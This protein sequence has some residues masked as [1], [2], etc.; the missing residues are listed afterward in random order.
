M[1]RNSSQGRRALDGAI[2]Q[3]QGA[4]MGRTPAHLAAQNAGEDEVSVALGTNGHI[5]CLSGLLRG[6]LLDLNVEDDRRLTPWLCA[7][8]GGAITAVRWLLDHRADVYKVDNTRQNVLHVATPRAHQRVV[9]FLVGYDADCSKLKN[10][11]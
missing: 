6:G 5:N 9:R 2:P 3:P 11:Q 4:L 7:C 10:S 8:H 1:G